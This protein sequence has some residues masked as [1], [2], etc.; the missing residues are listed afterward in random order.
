MHDLFSVGGSAAAV[1]Q[2]REKSSKFVRAQL[3]VPRTLLTAP[4]TPDQQILLGE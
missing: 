1:G 4:L 2:D 3:V